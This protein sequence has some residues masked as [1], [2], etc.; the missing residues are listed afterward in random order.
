MVG[1]QLQASG[2]VQSWMI[3]LVVDFSQARVWVSSNLVDQ[4]NVQGIAIMAAGVW[5]SSNFDGCFLAS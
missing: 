2:A 5:V 3:T 1:V 4:I